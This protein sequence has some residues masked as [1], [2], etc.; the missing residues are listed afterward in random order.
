MSYVA[1]NAALEGF[2]I[3]LLWLI[4]FCMRHV[5]RIA[6][7]RRCLH[8]YKVQNQCLCLVLQ[9]ITGSKMERCCDLCHIT[10]NKNAVVGDVSA[11][12]PGNH[13]SH[14]VCM[15]TRKE[16]ELLHCTH[17]E[18]VYILAQFPAKHHANTF[19]SIHHTASS[20][21]KMVCLLMLLACETG[22]AD[23]GIMWC[24]RGTYWGARHDLQGSEGG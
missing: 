22:K 20:R 11:M 12:T 16:P 1:D 14:A 15:C 17:G 8:T 9:K 13:F 10:L 24:R 5:R 3:R 2:C 4:S 23:V 18:R 19:D 6:Q 21:C 7:Q